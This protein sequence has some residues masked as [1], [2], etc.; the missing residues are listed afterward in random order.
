MVN[1]LLGSY[2]SQSPPVWLAYEPRASGQAGDWRSTLSPAPASVVGQPHPKQ[3]QHHQEADEQ[4]HRLGRVPRQGRQDKADDQ[5]G[6]DGA[7]YTVHSADGSLGRRRPIQTPTPINRLA[8]IVVFTIS[9][10]AP[11][12]TRKISR[13]I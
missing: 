8:A 3:H 13:A 4:R 2:T 6:Q 5:Q 1:G 11:E 10:L 9:Q 12:A 7:E